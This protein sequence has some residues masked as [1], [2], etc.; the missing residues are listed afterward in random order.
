MTSSLA[1][2]RSIALAARVLVLRAQLVRPLDVVRCRE[3]PRLLRRSRGAVAVRR[4]RVA[5]LGELADGVDEAKI[6]PAVGVDDHRRL[7]RRRL[8]RSQR[9]KSFRLPLKA[10]SM[11]VR[12]VEVSLSLRSRS[13]SLVSVRE[14]ELAAGRQF[15]RLRPETSRPDQTST[16]P[17]TSAL[18]LFQELSHPQ[19]LIPASPHQLVRFVP[20]QI[21][22]LL[23][24]R[25]VHRLRPSASWLAWAPPGGSGMIS[26]M[27]RS[28]RRSCAVMRSARRRLLAHL[29]ALAVLPQDRRAALDRDHR[30]DRVLEHVRAVGDAERERAARAAFADHRRDDRHLEPAHLEQV[31]AIAS[32]CP[33]SSAPSPAHAPIVSMNVITGTWNFS[34][35][36]IRRS[37]LR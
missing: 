4:A 27:T 10:T 25:V 36:F 17:Q 33:R 7:E 32:D 24:E 6:L 13:R 29:L 12:Q 9:K 5:L 15:D 23:H 1:F 35:S 2:T 22:E 26:S 21:L 34:A 20:T 28:S 16:R 37:A 31:R 18:S 14:A 3:P 11:S 30:V 19:K 8:V